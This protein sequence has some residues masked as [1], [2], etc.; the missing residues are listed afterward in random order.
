MLQ[1]HSRIEIPKLLKA[2]NGRSCVKCGA[3]DG[4]IVRA[5]YSGVGSARLGK[6]RGV[7]PHDFCSAD[8]CARCHAEFDGY[9]GGNTVER[10]FDFLMLCMQTLE[11]DFR[12]G[13]VG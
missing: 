7:K 4:T 5:H 6:G 12:E 1:K 2:S 9:E 11:R 13:V 8:L 10:G 3:D